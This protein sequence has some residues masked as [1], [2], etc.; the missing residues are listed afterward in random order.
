MRTIQAMAAVAHEVGQPLTIEPIMVRGPGPNEVLVEMKASGVCHTDLSL[1]NGTLPGHNFPAVFGHEGAGV[2]LEC[3]AEVRNFQPGDRVT[4]ANTP[5]CGQCRS[6]KEGLSSYCDQ[7]KEI[8]R[9]E[10]K[11][12]LHGEPLNGVGI[13]SFA[14]HSLVPESQVI[15]IPDSLSFTTAALIPCGVVTGV[16]AAMYR[17]RVT[18]GSTVVVTG[19]GSAGLNSVQGAKLV[20]AERIVAVDTN[21]DKK[22][23]AFKL[24]ATDFVNPKDSDKPLNIVLTDLLGGTADF[25]IEC[26][27]NTQ[28]LA[29][30]VTA[31]NPYWGSVVALG[32][33]SE[34]QP[35]ELPANA[36]W[37]GRSISGTFMGNANPLE[38]IPFLIE[39]YT[40]GQVLLDELVS[41]VLPHE[42]INDAFDLMTSGKSIRTVVEY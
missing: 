14:S 17:A 42:R 8:A 24:G 10:P 30:L 41:H 27:G 34:N 20:K 16:G 38:M 18:P 33:A 19:M 37:S 1:L 9:R 5:H 26:A 31:V 29:E 32:I 28:V 22:A 6:C 15:P 25:A 2:V 12:T 40:S 35:I 3:G 13:S 21:S 7:L 36:F 23:L 39:Q 4:L 11:Y